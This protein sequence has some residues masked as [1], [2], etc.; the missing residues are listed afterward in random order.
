[1]HETDDSERRVRTTAEE[2]DMFQHGV[3]GHVLAVHPAQL[4]LP[5]LI[6]EMVNGEIDFR[7]RDGIERAVRDLAGV[8]L[9]HREGDSIRP[10]R[11]ALRF[12]HL[13]FDR[14]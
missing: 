13:F 10:T 12:N 14:D 1:M 2:D 4:T 5:E 8:G 3:L 6:R 7:H 11:A 9:L